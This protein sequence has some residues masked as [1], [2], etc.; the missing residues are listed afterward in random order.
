MLLVV[1]AEK[2]IRQPLPLLVFDMRELL[3]FMLRQCQ[4]CSP[5]SR[6]GVFS[7]C[8]SFSCFLV[9]LELVMLVLLVAVEANEASTFLLESRS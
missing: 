8:P 1:V 4:F 6:S 9:V 2:I 5:I 3:L 7:N